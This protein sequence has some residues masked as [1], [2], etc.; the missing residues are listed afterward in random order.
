MTNFKVDHERIENMYDAMQFNNE[1]NEDPVA[2]LRAI[3]EKLVEEQQ[4]KNTVTHAKPNQGQRKTA[5]NN[6]N[7]P[8]AAS[9]AVGAESSVVEITTA[10]PMHVF[11]KIEHEKQQRL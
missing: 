9:A 10:N 1:Y 6:Q 5:A 2:I 7:S 3:H 11:R 8:A 4:E